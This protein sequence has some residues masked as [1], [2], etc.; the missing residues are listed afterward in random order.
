MSSGLGLSSVEEVRDAGARQ[1]FVDVPFGLYRDDPH[2]IPPSRSSEES[3][4]TG[5]H[6]CSGF[7]E[8]RSFLARAG[9]RPIGRISAFINRAASDD[10]R[11]SASVGHFECVRDR[12]V[13]GALFDAALEWL[14]GCGAS[15]VRGPVNGSIWLS[16]RL[17]TRGFGPPPFVGEPYNMPYY[18][19]LFE[20]ANFEPVQ[21]WISVI[22]RGRALEE[23]ASR[24]RSAREDLVA[25]GFR[26]RP[27]DFGRLEEE[28]RLLHRLIMAAFSGMPGFH[29]LE[30]PVFY[31]L[32]RGVK[33]LSHPNL[34]RI[35][36]DP[37]GREF[38]FGVH[39][40]DRARAVRAMRGREN[41][42]ARIRFLMHRRAAAVVGLWMGKVAA[43]DGPGDTRGTGRALSDLGYR[44]AHRRGL[45]MI[46]ALMAGSSPALG[47][48]AMRG[49]PFREYALYER[50]LT[51]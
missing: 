22:P 5:R 7:L 33:A 21:S 8:V 45:P 35:A 40:L 51:P 19:E 13:S 36:V 41:L 50:R 11:I 29:A 46:H 12:A 15:A 30:F 6:A 2:W 42:R 1:E 32:F 43:A 16:Y 44:E 17:M 26:F 47:F 34:I 3:L 20:A 37:G 48:T 38:G 39:L 27:L 9:N 49:D 4:L 31:R 28:M 18:S 24:G 25:R 23:Y 14:A 10:G